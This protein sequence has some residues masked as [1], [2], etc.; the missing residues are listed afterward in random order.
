MALRKGK[1]NI[2]LQCWLQFLAVLVKLRGP[3]VV[4]A[5]H[6]ALPLSEPLHADAQDHSRR[7]LGLKLFVQLQTRGNRSFRIYTV[8]QLASKLCRVQAFTLMKVSIS[9]FRR[10]ARASISTWQ[11]AHMYRWFTAGPP[12]KLRIVEQKNRQLWANWK[13][14][15]LRWSRVRE[16]CLVTYCRGTPTHSG[17]LSPPDHLCSGI[18]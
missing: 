11:M 3:T 13:H 4:F 8:L 2:L 14:A 12:P 17:E 5:L 16:W 6:K 15:A 10:L 1:R 9:I 18:Y 7:L